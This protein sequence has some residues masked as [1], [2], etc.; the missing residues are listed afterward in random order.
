MS[1]SPA[2]PDTRTLIL[3]A[4]LALMQQGRAA[5][6]LVQVAKA[7][8]VSRQAVYLHFAD[9]ADLYLSLVRHIDAKR[10]LA[11]AIARIEAAPDSQAMLAVAVAMQAQMNPAL[12]PIAAAMDAVRGEDPAI[13]AAWQDRLNHRREGAGGMIARLEAEGLLR[14]DLDRTTAAD[15]LWSLLSLRMWEDLV[16]LRGW[17]AAQYERELLGMIRRTLLD[18]P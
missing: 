10:D 7:A 11:G 4:A 2:K 15:L 12:Y 8:G 3:D 13:E 9:R 17:S 14:P 1:S 6:N 16:V 18:R 5:A